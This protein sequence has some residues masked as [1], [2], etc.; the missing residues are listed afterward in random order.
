MKRNPRFIR[1]FLVTVTAGFLIGFGVPASAMTPAEFTETIINDMTKPNDGV[2]IGYQRYR[3]ANTSTGLM[4]R[5]DYTAKWWQP[6]DQSLKSATWWSAIVPWWNVLPLQGNA[7]S[8]TRV[9]VGTIAAMARNRWTGAWYTVFSGPSGW[10]GNYNANASARVGPANVING[11]IS[12]YPTK[13]YLPPSGSN[14]VHGGSGVFSIKAQDMNGII[15][16]LAVRLKG[17]DASVAKYAMWGGAD[18][19]PYKGFSVAKQ[20]A[21]HGWIPAIGA[22]R[23][24][25]ITRA[26][27]SYCFAPLDN[28]GHAGND[29]AYPNSVG[30]FMSTAG[31]RAKPVA[32]IPGLMP[33]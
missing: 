33:K 18:W 12:G 29:A 16:C 9:E 27:Q 32:P 3:Y 6:Y 1:N 23:M 8:K 26:W 28:P 13:L 30:V 20:T 10:A 21:P 7:A 4:A 2:Q 14:T 15:V 24:K 25:K 17:P 22:A 11:T 5:G 31:L 19:Y